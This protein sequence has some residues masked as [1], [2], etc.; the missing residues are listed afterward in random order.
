MIAEARAREIP[1]PDTRGWQFPF[2]FGITGT[3]LIFV[4]GMLLITAVALSTGN[5]LL[6][7]FLALQL[8]AVIASG[9]IARLSLRSLFVSLQVPEN[10]FVGESVSIKITLTNRKRFAPSFSIL[11][12]DLSLIR[13][14]RR[15]GRAWRIMRRRSSRLSKAPHPPV[16]QHAAY[17]PAVP[18][19]R[20]RSELISQSFSRRGKY[21]L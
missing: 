13:A 9:I 7:L 20:A 2:S 3:G 8:S 12:E 10:V 21:R 16:L 6:Y 5:N 17:F 14:R 19:G 4:A 18:A 15:T 1:R 11:I